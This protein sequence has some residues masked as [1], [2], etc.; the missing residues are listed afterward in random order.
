LHSALTTY[1]QV[2]CDTAILKVPDPMEAPQEI[3]RDRVRERDLDNFLVEEL[4]ASVTFRA[5]FLSRLPQQ[6]VPPDDCEARLHKSPKRLQDSRQTDVRL[7]WFDATEALRACILIESKVTADFQP[8]Q[9]ESYAA[10]VAEYRAQLGQDF[11]HAVLVAPVA[12]MASLTGAKLF[13]ATVTIEEI[14]QHLIDRRVRGIAEPELDTRLAV[15][16]ALLEALA[17]KKTSETWVPLTVATK[18]DFANS[19]IEL[20]RLIVPNLKVQ[21]STDGPKALTRMFEGL[22]IQPDFPCKVRLKHEFGNGTG[23]KY[24]NIQFNGLVKKEPQLRARPDLFNV[25]DLFVATSEK[26]LFV[27]LQT[28]ALVPDGEQFEAQRQKVIQGLNAVSKLASWFELHQEQLSELLSDPKPTPIRDLPKA[29]E[30]AMRALADRSDAECNY[31]S[32][33]FLK[34]LAEKGGV[35]TARGLLRGSPSEG[36][37]KLWELGRPDLTVES[38]VLEEAWL[39]LFSDREIK[40]AKRRLGLL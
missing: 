30:S 6:M 20:A 16:T 36:F 10:E 12:K 9:A 15:R 34:M 35:E 3:F 23:F 21:I 39:A 5:W 22:P 28:P 8:G 29:F 19:Y 37:T 1:R 13:Q 24:A 33:P 4:Q 11:V 25:Q 18:R 38:L 17:G 31:R 26:S 2:P 40:T 7:G 14:I 27:R 32:Y